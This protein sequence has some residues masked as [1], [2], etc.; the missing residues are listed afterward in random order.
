MYF[1]LKVWKP[2]LPCLFFD[3]ITRR[4]IHL[5]MFAIPHNNT[6]K[7]NTLSQSECLFSIFQR[8]LLHKYKIIPLGLRYK[9]PSSYA[10]W[11]LFLE[12]LDI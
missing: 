5:E 3:K 9:K 7:K 10:V 12:G 4:M 8:N 11:Q 2:E 6:I 1:L